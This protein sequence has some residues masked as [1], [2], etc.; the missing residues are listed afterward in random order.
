M[1][2]ASAVHCAQADTLAFTV[3]I[4][5]VCSELSFQKNVFNCKQNPYPTGQPPQCGHELS[6][7][8]AHF[9]SLDP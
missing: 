8:M 5:S 7:A 2:T 1:H 9:P 3:R 4:L 6:L